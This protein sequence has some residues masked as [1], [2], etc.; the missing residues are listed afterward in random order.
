[1]QQEINQLNA[2]LGKKKLFALSPESHEME[3][4][5]RIIS[6]VSLL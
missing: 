2:E 5:E 6:R 1:M 3:E 4:K